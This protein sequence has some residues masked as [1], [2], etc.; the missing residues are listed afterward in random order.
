MWINIVI[1]SPKFRRVYS[2]NID[3]IKSKPLYSLNKSPGPPLLA[4]MIEML[5][6]VPARLELVGEVLLVLT[7]TLKRAG[8]ES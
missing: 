5:A 8:I 3:L 6:R 1:I 7:P 2:P 4:L